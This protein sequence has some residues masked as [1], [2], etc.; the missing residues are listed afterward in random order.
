MAETRKWLRSTG[1]SPDSLAR[2]TGRRKI[3]GNLSP[4]FATF[5]RTGQPEP[6]DPGQH[7][8][9]STVIVDPATN[10]FGNPNPH[11]PANMF[12]IM[13][14][15]YLTK[16]FNVYADYA[17]T[18]NSPLSHYDLGAGGRGVTTDCHD[19]SQLA[20]PDA[21]NGGFSGNGPRCWAGGRLQGISLGMDWTF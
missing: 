8:T 15:H 6:G 21:V 17:L 5:S 9:G 16:S 3:T 7:N 20:A 11:N 1:N 4:D 18:V 12:T 19:A 13:A 2:D 14:K 10:V